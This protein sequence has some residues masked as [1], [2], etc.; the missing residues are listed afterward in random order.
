VNEIA[1]NSDRRRKAELM[2]LRFLL[3]Y[4]KWGSTTAIWG[5]CRVFPFGQYL[6]DVNQNWLE[7]FIS[8]PSA[9][10]RKPD[11]LADG[12]ITVQRT[13]EKDASPGD[14]ERISAMPKHRNWRFLVGFYGQQGKERQTC[15]PWRQVPHARFLPSPFLGR[16]AVRKALCRRP[17]S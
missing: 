6:W 17:R 14:Q 1:R 10:F 8:Q 13:N 5:M 2:R 7:V 3:Q 15:K 12:T 16:F 9:S 11:N 4:G